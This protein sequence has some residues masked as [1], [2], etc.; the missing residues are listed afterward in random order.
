MAS[1]PSGRPHKLEEQRE[2]SGGHARYPRSVCKRVRPRSREFLQHL[3]GKTA[4]L[5]IQVYCLPTRS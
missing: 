5:E 4:H 3:A 1:V 2:G